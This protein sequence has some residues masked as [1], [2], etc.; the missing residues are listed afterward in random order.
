M[1][2]GVEP[3]YLSGSFPSMVSQNTRL[4]DSMDDPP[5]TAGNTTAEIPDVLVNLRFHLTKTHD[6][7]MF[8][9]FFLRTYVW[10]RT[11][12][13]TCPSAS[14][15]LGHLRRF[16]WS[17]LAL[18]CVVILRATGSHYGDEG[19]EQSGAVLYQWWQASQSG[20]P[21]LP[22]Q[23]KYKCF[24]RCHTH[25]C[26]AHNCTNTIPQCHAHTLST[27]TDLVLF[28]FS[29]SLS[30]KATKCPASTKKKGKLSVLSLKLNK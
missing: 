20:S 11:D 7:Q 6:G 21:S 10:K 15:Q 28:F 25:F 26:C 2:R 3:T 29:L 27:C 12:A 13:C 16:F 9:M 22:A 18:H 4:S 14:S 1:F 19:A 5:P 23:I 24:R 30:W 17:V 8:A